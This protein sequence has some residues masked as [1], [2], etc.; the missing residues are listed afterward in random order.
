[1]IKAKRNECENPLCP[2]ILSY[3]IPKLNAI[4]SASG[5]I[6][7][8]I[9]RVQNFQFTTDLLIVDPKAIAEN[10]CPNTVGMF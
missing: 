3:G 5:S 8:M 4:T 9:P 7:A 1:M 6:E 10:V 2:Q